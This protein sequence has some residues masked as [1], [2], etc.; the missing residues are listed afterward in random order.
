[1]LVCF[2]TDR[3]ARKWE[4]KTDEETLNAAL[5]Q[6]KTAFGEKVT[7]LVSY[8]ITRWGKE[9][10]IYGAFSFLATNSSYKDCL[11]L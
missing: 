3:F 5:N 1:M 8:K 7:N 11:A 10:N 4:E 6:L 9:Q 2:L